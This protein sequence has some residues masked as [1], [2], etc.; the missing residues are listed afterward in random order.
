MTEPEPTPPPFVPY[1]AGPL[2]APVEDL[3][4]AVPIA[5]ASAGRSLRPVLLAAGGL[6]LGVML[7][8]GVTY[9]AV[10]KSADPTP[11]AVAAAEPTTVYVT[12]TV[13]L[14]VAPTTPAAAT[15]AAAPPPPPPAPTID[16]GTWTVGEDIPAGTYKAVGAGSDCYW[17]IYKSGTNQNDIIDNHV[18][19]GNL[20]VTLKAGQDFTSERCGVWTKIG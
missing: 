6:L 1:V 7:G 18:G 16:D 4:P 8:A 13:I 14:T 9:A 17:G 3:R 10:G 12:K 20:R 15:T 19:G 5:P 11:V 2:S